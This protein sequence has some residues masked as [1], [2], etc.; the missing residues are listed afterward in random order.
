MDVDPAASN[1]EDI[2][3]ALGSLTLNQGDKFQSSNALVILAEASKWDPGTREQLAQL[4]VL[5]TLL[6]IAECSINDSLETAEVTLRCIGNACIENETAK[7]EITKRGFSWAK[8]C[9]PMIDQ[10]GTFQLS[11][12]TRIAML[13]SKVLYNVCSDYEPAQQKCFEEHVH[14]AII[15]LCQIDQVVKSDDRTLFIELLFW[16]C[17]HITPEDSH[18]PLGVLQTLLSLPYRYQEY[19]ENEDFALVVESC[20][21]FLRDEAVKTD[22]VAQKSVEHVWQMLQFN[23]ARIAQ[24]GTSE[25]DRRILRPLSTG[26]I[27]ILSDLAAI[28]QYASVYS[29][30]DDLFRDVLFMIE[31]VEQPYRPADRLVD[32]SCQLLGNLLWAGES[33]MHPDIA[34][35]L[36]Q[37]ILRL[38][39]T[40]EDAELLHSA[41]GLLLQLLRLS[42]ELCETVGASQNTEAVLERLCRHGLPQLRQDGVAILR[43]LG[44]DSRANQD[45]FAGLA[46]EVMSSSNANDVT[47]M[48][49]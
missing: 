15:G 21:L 17:S 32:A 20:L 16:I 2:E 29:T 11:A 33:P 8:Q 4:N 28:P 45:R 43:I 10:N 42:T 25:D 18:P 44:K 46:K 22:A 37:P 13:T 35:R 14:Y 6:E 36:Q 39:K 9:L 5:Q 3:K 26:L 31:A 7:A 19:V 49:P 1:I 12:D 34:E 30:D 23:E 41:A 48:E 38:L 24:P 47:M 40:S 27:W